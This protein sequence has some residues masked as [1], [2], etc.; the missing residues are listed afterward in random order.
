MHTFGEVLLVAVPG[1]QAAMI[2]HSRLNSALIM[3]EIL[4]S[5]YRHQ[6]VVAAKLGLSLSVAAFCK[7]LSADFLEAEKLHSGVVLAEP[8]RRIQTM[9]GMLLAQSH[10]CMNWHWTDQLSQMA[11]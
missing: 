10:T 5:I 9:L 1:V 7:R 4:L 11:T 6:V 8:P 2:L 3:A